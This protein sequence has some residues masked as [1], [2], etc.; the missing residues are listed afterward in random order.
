MCNCLRSRS[1]VDS[2]FVSYSSNASDPLHLRDKKQQKILEDDNAQDLLRHLSDNE[3]V[4]LVVLD[5]AGLSTNREDL[6]QLIN[7]N[8]SHQKLIV[9]TMP[10]NNK[11]TVYERQKLLNKQQTMKAFECRNR[12]LQRSK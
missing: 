5:H 12:P 2:V 8:E 10:F 7:D 4:C 11:V 9:D 1:L 6:E 3:K